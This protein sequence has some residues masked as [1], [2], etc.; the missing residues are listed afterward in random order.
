MWPNPSSPNL[1]ILSNH[2]NFLGGEGVAA[3]PT[4]HNPTPPHVYIFSCK[5]QLW[6]LSHPTIQP[7]RSSLRSNKYT[8]SQHSF[9]LSS[10]SF[11]TAWV[12]DSHNRTSSEPPRDR[13]S[14]VDARVALTWRPWPFFLFVSTSGFGQGKVRKTP[15]CIT[16]CVKV[17]KFW[18][19]K[20]REKWKTHFPLAAEMLGSRKEN[21]PH[22][23]TTIQ[24]SY[25][26]VL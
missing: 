11:I 9:S 14:A 7:S 13:V 6:A 1:P 12:L 4:S 20:Y 16:V 2:P 22:T 23:A 18:G 5:A 10:H 15:L 25:L 8:H 24:E 26:S 17:K 3:Y 21:S 19:H